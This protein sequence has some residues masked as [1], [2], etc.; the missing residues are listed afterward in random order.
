MNKY[1]IASVFLYIYSGT[2]SGF[3]HTR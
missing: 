1:L 2:R 3:P